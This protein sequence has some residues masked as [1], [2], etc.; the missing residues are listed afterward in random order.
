M[1]WIEKLNRSALKGIRR[2]SIESVE[3]GSEGSTMRRPDGEQFIR[4]AD[5]QEI[6]VVKQPSLAS[7][8]FALTVRAL[9]APMV[10]VDDSVPGFERFFE[11]L[12]QRLAGMVPYETWSVKLLAESQS[13]GQ[14]IFR[15]SC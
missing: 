6:A 10:I 4:W 12:P 3:T 7:G 13:T 9:D 8:S 15:R 2:H 11:E 1:Y 14:V 5:S